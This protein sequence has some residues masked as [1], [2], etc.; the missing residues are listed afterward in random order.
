MK[1]WNFIKKIWKSTCVYYTLISVLL[2]LLGLIDGNNAA[3][4]GFNTS[5][6]LFLPFGL[7]MAF[8]QELLCTA[9]LSRLSRYLGHYAIT[10]AAIVGLL[11]FNAHFTSTSLIL[12]IVF[13]SILYWIIFGITVLIRRRIKKLLEED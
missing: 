8:A 3:A 4:T 7:C 13:L 11:A 2:L 6:F 9:K 12:L 1:I 5:A 10:I